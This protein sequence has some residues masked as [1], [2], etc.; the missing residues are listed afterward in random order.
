MADK[1]PILKLICDD[2]KEIEE[3][4]NRGI[5]TL[6]ASEKAKWIIF[7][8]TGHEIR[9]DYGCLTKREA[10][11]LIEEAKYIILRNAFGNENQNKY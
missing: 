1:N 4:T 3:T 6:L 9:I 5:N 11:S 8:D 2:S 10:I 7:H